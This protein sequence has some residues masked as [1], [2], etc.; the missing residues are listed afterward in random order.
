MSY[1]KNGKRRLTRREVE[2]ILYVDHSIYFTVQSYFVHQQLQVYRLLVD[3][4]VN[5]L[6]CRALEQ[7]QLMSEQEGSDSE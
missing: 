3:S 7:M 5:E 4:I 6:E 1:T 2:R